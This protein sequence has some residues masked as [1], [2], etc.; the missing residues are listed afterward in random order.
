MHQEGKMSEQTRSG[1]S[2]RDFVRVGTAAGLAALA[3]QRAHAAR[4]KP[5]KVGLLGCGGRGT[6][7]AQNHLVGN[8]RVKLVAMADLFEDR[9]KSSLDKLKGIKDKEVKGEVDVPK[10]NMFV[11]LDAYKGILDTDIDIL[12]EATLPYS[13]PKHFAAAVDAGKHIFTEKPAAVDPTGI[14]QFLAAAKKAEE[15]KLCVVAGTQRRH[16]LDYQETIRKIHDGAIGDIKA[17]RVYWCGS[18]PF[19]HERKPGWSDFE[20]CVRNWYAFCWVCGDNIVEQHVHNLDVA[21]WVMKGHPV[22][23]FASGGRAWKTD[24]PVFGDLWDQFSCDYEYA[25]GTPMTSMSRHWSK[26]D[27]GVFE[28]VV[29]TKGR[30]NCRDMM[31]SPAE[32]MIDPYVQEHIDL[33]DSIRGIKPYINEG[34]QVAESTMT[35]IMGRMSAYTGKALTWDQA[36]NS[37]LSIVPAEWSLTKS[38]PTG[39]IPRPGA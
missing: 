5:L 17:L 22:K 16:Q 37:P 2:R 39:P 25:D 10:K 11:G 26:C 15:K 38:Y 28:D 31:D 24:D 8:E 33:V 35:A 20:Y 7:A 21:N 12:I 27:G 23:V 1:M 36:L 18:I 30:S 4:L 34:S 9:L 32:K 14:R 29:G 6:G 3:A 19:T 13:R